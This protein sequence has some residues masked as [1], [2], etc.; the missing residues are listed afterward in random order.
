MAWQVRHRTHGL[1][2]GVSHGSGH[3]HLVSGCCR[4]LGVF[5]FESLDQITTFLELASGPHL[6]EH[7]RLYSDEFVIEEWD[8]KT[9]DLLLDEGLL[10]SCAEYLQ[11]SFSIWPVSI[12]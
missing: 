3:F 10:D 7:A 9:H 12:N 2:M 4:G 6:P 8:F 1:F 5:R 11:W